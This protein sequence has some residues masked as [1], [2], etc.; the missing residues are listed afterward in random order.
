MRNIRTVQLAA[1]VLA[2]LFVLALPSGAAANEGEQE[3]TS[4]QTSTT[5][6]GSRT[7]TTNSCMG[8]DGEVSFQ[9]T[10]QTAGANGRSTRSTNSGDNNC[11]SGSVSEASVIPD[12]NDARNA[13]DA[14][15]ATGTNA[16]LVVI[17]PPSM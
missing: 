11:Q 1:I 12:R 15:G 5:K 7:T 3:F 17:N 14:A 13:A 10:T 4:T 8:S 2:P 9:K 16:P 6:D